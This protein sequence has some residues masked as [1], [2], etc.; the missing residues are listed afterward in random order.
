VRLVLV[1]LAAIFVCIPACADPTSER[2]FPQTVAEVQSALK[3]LAGGTAGSLPVLDGFIASSVTGLEQYQRPYYKCSITVAPVA[4]GGSRVR[5]SAKITA[6]HNSGAKSGYHVLP[7][8]GR[9][10]SDL[11]DRLQQALTASP[12]AAVALQDLTSTTKRT[13][14]H[15]DQPGIDAPTVQFPKF[16]PKASAQNVGTNDPALQREAENLSEILRNQSH[17]ANLVAVKSNQT[18]VLQN[19]ALDAKVLFLASA[20]DEFEIIEQNPDWIHIRISGLSRGWLRRTGVELLDGSESV[21]ADAKKAV[22]TTTPASPSVEAANAFS[23]SSEE[24]GNFPGDWAPLKG[25]NVRI[26]SVQ[27][28]AGSGV[29]SGEDKLK[30]AE[31]TFQK[32]GMGATSAGLVVVFDTEDGGMI[33]AT[34]SSIEQY[35]KGTISEEAFW[36]QCYVDPPEVLGSAK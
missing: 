32:Q 1:A 33:A 16:D 8:N 20:E 29:T 34:A 18:P 19:P 15:S 7:S 9:L 5:V 6:W 13:M 17:P 2:S 10:E 27:S 22:S 28:A 36:K 14:G 11:L 3:D 21:P 26:I 24:T 12:G 23:V 30:F 4:S 35:K 25:K 31:A